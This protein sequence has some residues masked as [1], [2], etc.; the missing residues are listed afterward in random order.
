MAKEFP[1][2]TPPKREV[3]IEP[4]SPAQQKLYEQW[5]KE[6]GVKIEVE[7]DLKK[8][9]LELQQLLIVFSGVLS[10]IR[11]MGLPEDVNEFV[12]AIQK[13]ISMIYT[14][15]AA[16]LAL[17]AARAAGGDPIAMAQFGIAVAAT[18]GISTDMVS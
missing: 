3:E 7:V 17:Q 14:L 5:A 10:L 8:F 11:K 9:N 1:K 13:M 4:I 12:F 18:V 15:Q 6:S 16:I 2:W